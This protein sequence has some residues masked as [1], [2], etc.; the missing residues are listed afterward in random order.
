MNN[1]YH[2]LK[3]INYWST[4]TVESNTN[5]LDLVILNVGKSE[6]ILPLYFPRYKNFCF[7]ESFLDYA[8]Y[9]SR[10]QNF[11][12]YT[13]YLNDRIPYLYFDSNYNLEE[14]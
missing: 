13:N 7:N 4:K 8:I 2:P 10:N 1:L 5:V 9:Y 6:T 3:D 12:F 11:I 14:I